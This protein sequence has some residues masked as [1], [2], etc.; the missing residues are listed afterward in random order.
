[1]GNYFEKNDALTSQSVYFLCF[2]GGNVPPLS[3]FYQRHMEVNYEQRNNH[4]PPFD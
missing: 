1:M 3:R 4:Q 2:S